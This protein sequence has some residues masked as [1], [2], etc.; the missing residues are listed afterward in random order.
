MTIGGWGFGFASMMPCAVGEA[1]G[2]VEKGWAADVED[3]A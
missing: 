1:D 2:G 3:E